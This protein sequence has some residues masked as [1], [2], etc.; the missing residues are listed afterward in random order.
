MI[1]SHLLELA[2]S[3][4]P[5]PILAR[6]TRISF[7]DPYVVIIP[8]QVLRHFIASLGLTYSVHSEPV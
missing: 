7:T 5:L 8:L 6:Y 1:L 2:N 4:P 3:N